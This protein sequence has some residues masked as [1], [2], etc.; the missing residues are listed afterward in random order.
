MRSATI[1]FIGA[2]L[3]FL[4]STGN[5]Y[6]QRTGGSSTTGSPFSPNTGVCGRTPGSPACDSPL[7]T[8]RTLYGDV[9][10]HLGER[11]R[12]AKGWDKEYAKKESQKLIDALSVPCELVDAEHAGGGKVA[13]DGRMLDVTVYEAAC[14]SGTGY[15]L[16]SQPPEKSLAISCFAAEAS[17]T[18][19]VAQGAKPDDFACTLSGYK[20]AKTM[21]AAVLKGVGTVCDVSDYRWVG[22][23]TTT[24]T[25]YSEVSC[26]GGQGY[27]L[28]IPKTSQA[29]PLSVVDCQNAVK[30]GLKCAL[31]AV[32]LPVTLQTFRDA[33]KD[34]AVDCDPAEIRYIGRETQDRRYVVELQCP[35]QPK[36]LVVF[37][38]LQG[39]PKPFETVDCPTAATRA[40]QCKLTAKP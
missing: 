39:N 11:A 23:S 22:V 6:A 37:I 34:H 15:F 20:D 9:L 14:R 8:Q 2:S 30:E 19:D 33:I 21:A 16:V 29:A 36:G 18:A 4:G 13:V 31:T 27:V 40:V 24:G 3:V 1:M 12:R 38:P 5:L 28:E 35:Q 26:D 17:H 25:E 7:M 32:T 10:F